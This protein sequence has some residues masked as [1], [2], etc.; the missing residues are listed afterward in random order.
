MIA[1]TPM[2]A[3]AALAW[4]VVAYKAGTLRR[5]FAD[6]AGRYH[7][8]TLLC[9]A[10]A[11]TVLLP[12]TY[13][14]IDRWSRVPN[15]ARLLG[16]GSGLV[17]SWSAQALLFHLTFPLGAA[18]RRTRILGLVL[19]LVLLL[20]A[21]CFSLAWLP[22][23][24]LD[25]T[26][27]YARTPFI[28]EYRVVFLA[29]LGLGMVNAARLFWRY[30]TLAR[31]AVLRLSLRLAAASSA[32]GLAYVMNEGLR[33]ASVRFGHADPLPH[34]A[35]VSAILLVTFIVVGLASTTVAVWGTR[36]RLEACSTWLGQYRSLQRL[37]P[38]W[39]TLYRF[40][41]AIAL[42][43]PASRLSDLLNWRRVDFRLY[44]RVVEIRDGVLLLRPHMDPGAA[45]YARELAGT[46]GL[47]ET[48]IQAVLEAAELAVAMRA[49]CARGT[50]VVDALPGIPSFASAD[51]PSEIASLERLARCFRHSPIVRQVVAA[52]ALEQRGTL[53]MQRRSQ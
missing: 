49:P 41:A 35:A 20:M 4:V 25:F 5:R 11:L 30:A 9:L 6:P 18:T 15:L 7:W 22:D 53:S 37:Y 42:D 29:F 48:E 2:D 34:P 45:A 32:L 44:R 28:F 13:L 39:Q 23:E 36:L 33:V 21:V 17:A 47:P 10:L 3:I 26:G 31:R 50:A 27:R 40:D 46:A 12:Q 19:L 8:L 38:L 51:L 24:A 1:L 14:T 16:D 52:F 43:P